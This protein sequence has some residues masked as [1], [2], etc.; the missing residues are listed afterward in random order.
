VRK[1]HLSEAAE[2]ALAIEGVFEDAGAT[3]TLERVRSLQK[4][5][6]RGRGWP[7][8]VRRVLEAFDGLQ[9]ADDM[10]TALQEIARAMVSI[11]G[12]DRGVVVG[13]NQRGMV[14][15]EASANIDGIHNEYLRVSSSIL[16]HVKET[17]EPLLI[18]SAATD[19]RFSDSSSIMSFEIGSVVCVPVRVEDNLRAVLYIDSKTCGHPS[20]PFCPRLS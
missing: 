12:A 9:A 17:Q 7:D 3:G 20:T 15:F 13:L 1:G 16:R 2:L 6:A 8:K 4:Q 11:T 19:S 5:V 14:Q 10:E 18:D